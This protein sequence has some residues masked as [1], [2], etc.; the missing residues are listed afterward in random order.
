VRDVLPQVIGAGIG[1]AASP[2]VAVL[3]I[4]LLTGASGMKRALSFAAGF[5]GSLAVIGVASILGSDAGDGPRESTIGYTIN[6]VLGGLFLVMALKQV[7]GQPDP[8]APSNT[9]M[10]TFDRVSPAKAALFGALLG[11]LNLKALAIFVQG[12]TTIVTAELSQAQNLIALIILILVSSIG[13]LAPIG[14][15]LLVPDRSTELLGR[16][17]S[18]LEQ[19]QRAIMVIVLLLFGSAFLIKGLRGLL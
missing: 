14:V 16:L 10:A 2:L 9:I 18:W 6:I 13:L 11:G 4:I 15:V 12:V 3:G 7:L 17:R 19:R 1:V 8:D 5:M